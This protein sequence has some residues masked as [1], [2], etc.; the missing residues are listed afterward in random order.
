MFGLT[1]EEQAGVV[2]SDPNRADIACFV[3][4]VAVRPGTA[5]PAEIAGW[6]DAHGWPA[7]PGT[8]LDVPVPVDSWEVFDHLFDWESRAV[9]GSTQL[10]ATYLGTAVR[11]FFAQGGR[12]CYV[13]RVGDPLPAS[14]LRAHRIPQLSR[15]M[16]GYPFWP[17]ATPADRTSWS[18]IGHLFGLPDASFLC[19]PDLP[20][21]L[22][23]DPEPPAPPIEPPVASEQFVEC[24]E[25]PPAEVDRT[26]RGVSHPVC[27]DAGFAEWAGFLA[28]AA[29]VLAR[30]CREVQ[31]VA[32]V[33]L[34][35]PASR[36]AADLLRSLVDAGRGPL[37][38]R[39][40]DADGAL[41]SAFVQLSYPWLQTGAAGRLPG[42]AEPPDGVLAGLIAQTALTRGSFG[43]AAG[44]VP[45]D[46]R[47]VSPSLSQFQILAPEAPGSS[48]RAA[49][50]LV[51]RVSLFGLVPGGTT[52]LS[53]V[54]TSL[55]EAYRPAGSNR[56]VSAIVRAAR[57]L[58]EDIVFEP[59]G[60]ALWAR[61]RRSIESLLLVLLRQGALV[62]A[63]PEDAFSVRCDRSTMSQN[64]IDAGRVVCRIEFAGAASIERITVVLAL[65]EGGQVSLISP[66]QLAGVAA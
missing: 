42:G 49:H 43:S 16:P 58:G 29:G 19:L 55:D 60:E 38:R 22:S 14:E 20:E 31:L 2:E 8:L 33:P 21:I 63:S 53:D 64:D 59:S 56:L 3:G 47:G 7:G 1:F 54:T 62:G 13:I 23:A 5:V 51:E 17:T 45:I 66:S 40:G 18:G 61:I 27:D 25:E 12:K 34:P 52:L 39:L 37:A 28:M 4:F 36:P 32:A 48:G 26:L 11:S 41:S 15:L 57:L 9:A 24:S 46:V 44:S 10:A 35:R 65:D 6:L 50:S 30:W